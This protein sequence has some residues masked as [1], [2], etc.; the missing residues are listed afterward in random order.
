MERVV[1]GIAAVVQ[2]LP[3]EEA[4]APCIDELLRP[5][6]SQTA[7]ARDDA[8]RGDI[9]SAHTRGQLALKCIA[10]IGRG[11]RS[12]DSKVIDLESEETPWD[13]NSF[14][15]THPLQEQL[16]QCLLVYLDGFPLEHEII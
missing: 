11:L 5:F 15:D 9:E 2:A 1:E 13:D 3:S 16:R 7:S 10:G 4:K 12:D 8:Q 6:F 14:W